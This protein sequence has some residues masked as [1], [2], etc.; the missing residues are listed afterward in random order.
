MPLTRRHL[1]IIGAVATA[2]V[3][4]LLVA[5]TIGVISGRRRSPPLTLEQRAHQLLANNP[6][7]DG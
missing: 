1:I 2:L 5:V 7:I 4:A 6:L 3:I